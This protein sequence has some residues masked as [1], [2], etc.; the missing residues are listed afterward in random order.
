MSFQTALKNPVS[1]ILVPMIGVGG[2]AFAIYY[3]LTVANAPQRPPQQLNLPPSSSYARAISG[4]GLIESNS[5]NITV[6]STS[7]GIVR[8]LLVTEGD[9]VAAGAP[10]FRLDNRT[11]LADIAVA[12]SQLA[13]AKAK[14]QEAESSL[15][16]QKDQLQRG[17]N[18][19]AGISISTDRL[20]RL[21]YAVRMADAQL[22]NAKAG[23]GTADAQLFAA[24]VTLEKLTV[25]A[26]I[27]GKILKVSLRPGQY[28]DATS[29]TTAPIIMGND[30]PLHI[31]VSL[32]ENDLWRLKPDAPAT[33]ALRSN[34]DIKFP[35]EFVRV[36]PYVIPKKSLTGSTSE[37]VD[38]RI[39]EVIYKINTDT[40]LP[41]YIGQQVD[42]FI[43]TP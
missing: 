39:L 24:K 21:R 31:R 35:L 29:S 10:L 34:R 5:R 28:V 26:P 15:A 25:T 12:E 37:R 23:V 22:A 30:T 6:G 8:D 2:I 33:G 40:P 17:E 11:A 7:S 36:E 13:A 4:S 38:T 43:E 9:T 19:K 20:V 41:L 3:S 42:V 18:L 16:D 32:D 27:A 1:R 14:V